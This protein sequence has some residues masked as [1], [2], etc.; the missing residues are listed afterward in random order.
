M[1]P[2]LLITGLL[3]LIIS[4]S[5]IGFIIRY[6]KNWFTKNKKKILTIIIATGI[7]TGGGLLLPGD[8]IAGR[9]IESTWYYAHSENAYYRVNTTRYF[10]NIQMGA[11]EVV[12]NTS[13]FRFD[14]TNRANITIMYLRNS[15]TTALTGQEI[16]DVYMN[17]SAQLETIVGGF[18]PFA[19]YTCIL[20]GTTTYTIFANATG[21]IS[22]IFTAPSHPTYGHFEYYLWQPPINYDTTIRK[23]GIDYFIWMGANTT[24]SVVDNAITGFDTSLEY[25]AIWTNSG[26]WGKWYGDGTGSNWN[27]HTFDVVQSYLDNGAGTLTFN[28]TPNPSINYNISRTINLAKKSYGYNYTGYTNHSATQLMSAAN[29]TYLLLP[30]GY[31]LA[32]WNETTYT[33]NYWLSGWAGNINQHLSKY[34]IIMTRINVDKTWVI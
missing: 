21:Y 34:D 26:S 22:K 25:I 16:L 29:T 2:I 32:L 18:T 14:S 31:W 23:T 6:R 20:N 33:W 24:A 5:V 11:H 8:I 1:N 7:L 19:R 9:T 28:M 3:L 13:S 4:V 17:Y 10:H 12:F 27:I 15:P 30:R